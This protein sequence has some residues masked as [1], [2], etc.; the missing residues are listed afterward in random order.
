MRHLHGRGS[1]RRGLAV[2]MAMLLALSFALA[3][4][5]DSE[6]EVPGISHK[7]TVD[8]VSLLVILNSCGDDAT[9]DT[10]STTSSPVKGLA[11]VMNGFGIPY[12]EHAKEFKATPE[13]I[14]DSSY[15]ANKNRGIGYA[16][17]ESHYPANIKA[18]QR[19]EEGTPGSYVDVQTLFNN[20]TTQE[21]K[22]GCCMRWEY[23]GGYDY[24]GPGIDGYFD[25]LRGTEDKRQYIAIHALNTDKWCICCPFDYGPAYDLPTTGGGQYAD[26]R[27]GGVSPET[28]EA[29]GFGGHGECP[30]EA[31][32]EWWWVE[33]SAEVQ[34]GPVTG[35]QM[36]SLTD[37]AASGAAGASTASS[38][39]TERV[40]ASNDTKV[41]VAPLSANSIESNQRSEFAHGDLPKGSVKYLV[42]HDSL[43]MDLSSSTIS[44]MSDNLG[45]QQ[46]IPHFYIDRS[47][48]VSQYVALNKIA[49]HAGFADQG[50]NSKFGI[51]EERDDNVGYEGS[52]ACDKAMNAWSIGIML[53]HDDAD[54]N[55]PEAQLNALDKLIPY[56]NEQVGSTPQVISHKDWG[57]DRAKDVSSRF[58]IANYRESGN[59][60]NVK[61]AGD[62]RLAR[63]T[64]S[65]DEGEEDAED[66]G[67]D[68][69]LSLADTAV[70]LAGSAFP[71]PKI[72]GAWDQEPTQA[73]LSA[74]RNAKNQVFPGVAGWADCGRGVATAVRYSKADMSFPEGDT[75]DQF[76]YMTNSSKWTRMGTWNPGDDTSTLQPG[77][78]LVTEGKGHIMMF[79]GNEAVRKKYP[80]SPANFYEASLDDYYPYLYQSTESTWH[81]PYA[82]FKCTRPDVAQASSG[83][84]NSLRQAI[85]DY[86]KQQVANGA[87]YD[88]DASSGVEG[89]SY[90]CSFLSYCAYK[91]AG[92]VIPDCQ[93]YQ[94]GGDASQSEWIRKNGN[95]VTDPA[96]LKPGDLVFFGS[97]PYNTGHVGVSLGGR[98][99]IDSIP[100][101]GVQER[102][103][104]DSFVGG[105]WPLD[106]VIGESTST[107]S[108]AKMSRSK[109]SSSSSLSSILGGT[110]KKG[111]K[112]KTKSSA[113]TS[114]DGLTANQEK[115]ALALLNQGFGRVQVAGIM[116]NISQESSYNP[117]ACQSSDAKSPNVYSGYGLCQWTSLGR[118]QGLW[119]LAAQKGKDVSDI[120]VQME[121][122]SNEMNGAYRNDTGMYGA[123][124]DKFMA[125]T[126]VTGEDGSTQVWCWWMERPG[127]PMMENRE[128]E[129]QRIYDL[130]PEAGGQNS[131]V[132]R[133]VFIG[134]SRTVGMHNARHGDKAQSESTENGGAGMSAT[135]ANGKKEL[136][137]AKGSTSYSWFE[138]DAVPFL[139]KSIQSGDAI[140]IWMG[141][142]GLSQAPSYASLVKEKA[143]DWIAKGASVYYV[144]VGPIDDAAARNAG[145]PE[146]DTDANVIKFNTQL[147]AALGS[148]SS[149]TYIDLHGEIGTGFV[150]TDG[151]HYD[152]DTYNR[153]YDIIIS[154]VIDGVEAEEEEEEEGSPLD[155]DYD[156][157]RPQG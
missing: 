134:D 57:G 109:K 74:Y 128:A 116:G 8:Q 120:D 41:K 27:I 16:G 124:Y 13:P 22:Y 67:T 130:L 43:G 20:L 36:S 119:E 114:I 90:N 79:V 138:S 7:R 95:W 77:E 149:T 44:S 42:I 141:V 25:F 65:C 24:S 76:N 21:E 40:D 66:D 104:Y 55:Y 28:A 135:A 92:L 89:V 64:N 108:D 61:N 151:I 93:G 85:V 51:T 11:K 52:D 2:I 23:V 131:L 137:F 15:E 59:H 142:N 68:M 155:L 73:S 37:S 100:D 99:M 45:R 125:A 110:K 82:I 97:G 132:K 3:G 102:D 78:V 154:H 133:Y 4:C 71:D 146:V 112:K 56:I 33:N 145:Y 123:T 10:S 48:K 46:H 98:R 139:D 18:G 150:A 126:S 94:N 96:N 143:P 111:T 50:A 12:D 35:T 115:I 80:Q 86:C 91:A 29:L 103:L 60:N 122:L 30:D 117:D 144:S 9:E 129:A 5:D 81:R 136:W 26:G 140:I 156:I 121:H 38:A 70:Q 1:G 127:T 88:W 58:P 72:H 53:Q 31:L 47:G 83:G 105:G 75:N 101:G 54:G 14:T 87:V 106:A 152:P 49:H 107:K 147:K 148:G 32:T 113:I 39:S 34:C 118:K 84:G 63:E 62:M 157:L 153:I 6:D 17:L 69:S 19:H